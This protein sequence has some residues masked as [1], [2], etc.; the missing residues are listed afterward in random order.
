MSLTRHITEMADVLSRNIEL[1]EQMAEQLERERRDFVSH[2]VENLNENL[3]RKEVIVIER[4]N[5]Y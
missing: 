3:K 1:Y 2:S 5:G 4:Q